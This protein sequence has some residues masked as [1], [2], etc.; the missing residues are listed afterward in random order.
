MLTQRFA[1]IWKCHLD[2]FILDKNVEH[3]QNAVWV[4]DKTNGKV[5]LNMS[6]TTVI[7]HYNGKEVQGK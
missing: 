3:F 6:E 7:G 2:G 4:S 5:V 1:N